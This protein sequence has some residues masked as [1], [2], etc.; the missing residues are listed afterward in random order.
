MWYNRP[1]TT[2]TELF[3]RFPHWGVRLHILLEEAAD[4]SPITRLGR[5]SERRKGPRHA[6]W[7]TVAAFLLAVVLGLLALGLA[8]MQFW[9]GLCDWQGDSTGKS[10]G[11][12]SKNKAEGE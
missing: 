6:F 5:W 3:K 1:L 7:V 9:V 8:V 12:R 11:L 10:C 2:R 4:P